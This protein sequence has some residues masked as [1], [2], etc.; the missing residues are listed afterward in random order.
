MMTPEQINLWLEIQNR[1]MQALERIANA[2]EC[3]AP[4][5]TAAPNYTNSLESF[6][7][8]DWESIGAERGA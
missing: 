2:V 1:Q 5:T 3:L 7:S 8:F 6:L 4:T